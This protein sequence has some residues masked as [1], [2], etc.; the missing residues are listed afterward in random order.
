MISLDGL[1]A[2]A[3]W[4][5]RIREIADNYLNEKDLF[6]ATLGEAIPLLKVQTAQTGIVDGCYVQI[7]FLL[8]KKRRANN[9]V[10]LFFILMFFSPVTIEAPITIWSEAKQNKQTI[11]Q[12][13]AKNKIWRDAF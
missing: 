5:I 13:Y 6:G 7:L 8:L 12:S 3:P 11:Y 2:L 9:L 1:A 10:Y 4:L